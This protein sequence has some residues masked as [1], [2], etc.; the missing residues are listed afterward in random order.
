MRTRCAGRVGTRAGHAARVACY[1]QC[2]PHSRR[3]LPHGAALRRAFR[4]RRVILRAYWR[5]HNA[6]VAGSSPAPAIEEVAGVLDVGDFP[7]FGRVWCAT[8]GATKG[9]PLLGIKRGVGGFPRAPLA[10]VVT[11]GIVRLSVVASWS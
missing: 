5:T 8:S 9:P 1:P 6:G 7:R 2:Y 11:K 3:F 4:G 10:F